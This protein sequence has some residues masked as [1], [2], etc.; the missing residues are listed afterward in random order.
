MIRK[1]ECVHNATMRTVRYDLEPRRAWRW[2]RRANLL[3]IVMSCLCFAV[4]FGQNLTGEIDG[5]VKDSSGAVVP[6]APV[7]VTDTDQN[8]TVRTLRTDQQGRFTVPLLPVGRYSLKVEL[9]GFKTSTVS[10]LQVHVNEPISVPVVLSLGTAAQTVTVTASDLTLQLDSPAAGTLIDHT[11]MT[12]LSLSNRNFLQTLY[13]QPGISGGIPGPDARGNVTSTGKVNTQTFSVN[14][15]PVS[16]NGYYLDG[17]DMLKKAGQQPMVFPGVDFIQE[18]NLQRGS[19]G[20]Q[21]GGPGS[22]TVSIQSKSGGTSFHGGAFEFFRSQLLDANG[23]FNNLVNAPIPGL[24][25]NDYGYYLGGPVWIPGLSNRNTS[26][27]FFF[28][29]QEYLREEDSTQQHITN[30]PTA[31]QRQG[32][33]D[34]PV[35][36]TYN[37]SGKCSQTATSI[38]NIDPTAQAYLKDIVDKVPVPNNPSDPQGLITY[39]TGVDNETQTIIKI[40]HQFTQRLSAFFRYLDEP[41]HLLAPNGFTAPSAIPGV[42]I[43]TLTAGST[44]WLGHATYVVNSNNVLAGGFAMRQGWVTGQ[45]IGSMMQASSPDIQIKLPYATNLGQVPHLAISGATYAVKSPSD[46]RDPLMQIFL[47]ETSTTGRHTFNTGFSLEYDQA[48]GDDSSANAGNFRFAPGTLPP[49]GATQFDQ[50]FANFLLGNVS[51]FTQVSVDA[52]V[53][54]HSNVYEAYAQDDFHATQRL[55]LNAGIR[56]SY[57]AEPTSDRVPGLQTLLQGV[58]FDPSKYNYANAPMID[59]SGLICN[60]S[61]VQRRRD[62]Q[63]KL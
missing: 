32:I 58:N 61:S 35:C 40:D 39:S 24:R 30:V 22:A 63:S 55:T 33:F 49:G 6:N 13:L 21:F 9:A 23:Y 25:Y 53:A 1:H 38:T 3:L 44:N 42:A 28:F 19:Y 11:Q 31:L 8:L 27:T 4:S 45:G 10:D 34:A 12:Q 16:A 60:Q 59:S 5:V 48:G 17:Q 26:K 37:S 54:P 2:T 46:E 50:A 62:A 51:T 41:F 14:G 20:A 18:Q 57:M 52:A 7:T 15:L 56:Y 47:N 29:G 36:I 43:S